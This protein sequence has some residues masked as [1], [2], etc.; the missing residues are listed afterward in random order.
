[1]NAAIRLAT[2]ADAAAV[3]A[4]Y[5]PIVRDT[6]ISF[7]YTVPDATEMAG[8]I[9]AALAQY[10]WLVCDV[11]GS[12]A[13]YAYASAFRARRA[14]QWTAETTVYI[15]SDFQRRGLARALYTSLLA[16]LRKQGY[17]N[18]IGVIALPNAASIH[19]HEALGFQKVGIIKNA[20]YKAGS[21]HDTG[22][23]QLA[24]RPAD[25]SPQPPRPIGELAGTA[26]FAALQ[27]TG[28]PYIRR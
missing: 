26:D 1:M 15:H 28:L 27:A 6:H 16:I 11:G 2:T 7:E 21:W 24:L 3:L 12:V 25:A 4:I 8:R 14:Y 22:W 13:G 9:N 5:R 17:L 19:A 20:G 18:A 23:W 10:P